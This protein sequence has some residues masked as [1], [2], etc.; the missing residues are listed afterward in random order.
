MV[1]LQITLATEASEFVNQHI[2]SG[3]YSTPSEVLNAIVEEARIRESKAK[4]AVLLKEGLDSGPPIEVTE[5][6]LRQ[7]RAE[8]TSKL[9]PHS[10]GGTVRKPWVAPTPAAG[11]APPASG[12]KT[13]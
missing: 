3:R 9:P 6:W 1:E 12:G 2:A 13:R 8:L 7:Q 4:L 5:E 11:T 10:R